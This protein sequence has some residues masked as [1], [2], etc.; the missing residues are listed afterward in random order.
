MRKSVFLLTLGLALLLFALLAAP[1]LATTVGAY[2]YFTVSP[3]SGDPTLYVEFDSTGSA[4][5]E[6]ADITDYEWD[7][8]DGSDVAYGPTAN[9]N[10]EFPGVFT[11]SLL[12]TDSLGGSDSY[13]RTIT[14]NE[15]VGND[16]FANAIELTGTEGTG[17]GTTSHTAGETS[18]P[19]AGA[20]VWANEEP[21][22]SV[23]YKYTP[24]ADGTFA[25]RAAGYDTFLAAYT[26]GSLATLSCVFWNDDDGIDS[27]RSSWMVF[28][29]TANT[30]YYIQVD[31]YNTN[32]GDFSYSYSLTTAAPG[33]D[34]LENA[35]ALVGNSDDID[36]DTSGAT[37]ESNEPTD[38]SVGPGDLDSIWYSWTADVGGRMSL[39]TTADFQSRVR[40]FT[41]PDVADLTAVTGGWDGCTFLAEANTTYYIQLDG[42]WFLQGPINLAWTF[43]PAPEN[44]AFASAA[45]LTGETGHVTSHIYGTTGEGGE[46][47]ASGDLN[48]IWYKWVAPYTGIAYFETYNTS[49]NIYFAIF[50]GAGTDLSEIDPI[51]DNYDG[52][53]FLSSFDVD[54]V[55]DATYWIQIDGE[56]ANMGDFSLGWLRPIRGSTFT[57]AEATTFTYGTYGSFQVTTKGWPD[58]TISAIDVELLPSGLNFR[59]NGD[60]TADI[61]GT[62]TCYG[63]VYNQGLNAT[64]TYGSDDQT[65]AITVNRAIIITQDPYDQTVALGADA[66]FSCT[67]DGLEYPAVVSRQ[68]QKLA[69]GTGQEWQDITGA[70]GSSYTVTSTRSLAGYQ[71]RMKLDNG[72]DA[73]TYCDPARLMVNWFYITEQP[74]DAQLLAGATAG[75]GVSVDFSADEGCTFQWQVSS[76]A[77]RKWVD[78]VEATDNTLTVPKVTSTMN[79]YLYRCVISTYDT[80]YSRSAKLTVTTAPKLAA[81]LSVR[82]EVG[83]DPLTKIITWTVTVDNLSTGYAAQGIVLSDSLGS[84]TKFIEVTSPDVTGFTWKIGGRSLTVKFA[85]LAAG[86]RATFVVRANLGRASVPIPNAVSVTTT[87]TFDPIGLPAR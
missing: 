82:Q 3:S 73:P 46:P 64:N 63:G 62:P 2:A 47:A 76:S 30:T 39:A 52:E 49:C 17:T 21:L 15:V 69:P 72:V 31:G 42:D 14:V 10:Y 36:G 19:V 7:F 51:V 86:G 57:S 81:D 55:K 61:Y 58:A 44:D 1:A 4:P 87:G 13:E 38:D 48:T 32:V 41:G 53:Y 60:G 67:Y 12:I 80:F 8:G 5:G 59:N 70:T 20:E 85:T 78:I 23:W 83:Y 35:V 33:N 34:D 71:Y 43:D 11:A 66:S 28:P 65:L 68:W 16:R 40:V 56:A 22:H 29:V 26:G 74:W 45:T 37:A 50:D 75:F 79:G 77:G 25:F 6:D 9:H 84:G 27:S 18:E 54:V 24:G